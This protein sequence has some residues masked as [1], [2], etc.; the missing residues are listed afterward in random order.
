MSFQYGGQTAA[1][2]NPGKGPWPWG[3]PGRTGQ[4][5]R[6]QRLGFQRL[7]AK[8]TKCYT[9]Y[10]QRRRY[11]VTTEACYYVVG[12]MKKSVCCKMYVVKK[13]RYKTTNILWIPVNKTTTYSLLLLHTVA[14]SWSKCSYTWQPHGGAI[15]LHFKGR[16]IF[17]KTGSDLFSF[18]LVTPFF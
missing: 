1:K 15:V 18:C 6:S 11:K 10:S 16:E 3:K 4:W 14:V 17:N 7:Y 9:H 2:Y 13:K 8:R 5:L 12:F